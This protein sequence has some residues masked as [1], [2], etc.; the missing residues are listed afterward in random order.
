MR[1][2]LITRWWIPP[3]PSQNRVKQ[4]GLSVGIKHRKFVIYDNMIY[5]DEYFRNIYF[6]ILVD[7]K[8]SRDENISKLS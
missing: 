5:D 7:V 1:A 4:G 2:I 8:M 6:H 3:P